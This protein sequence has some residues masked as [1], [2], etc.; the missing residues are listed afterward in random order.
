MHFENWQRIK[1]KGPE[2]VQAF[3]LDKLMPAT[4][5]VL[6]DEIKTRKKILKLLEGS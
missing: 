4:S 2:N 1:F 5:T 3:V 6:G